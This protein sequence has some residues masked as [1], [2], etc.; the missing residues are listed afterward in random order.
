M[1]I[2]VFFVK[3]T[4]SP[5]RLMN[6]N[7]LKLSQHNSKLLFSLFFLSFFQHSLHVPLRAEGFASVLGRA[8]AGLP[9]ALHGRA[10][11]L[12]RHWDVHH[13]GRWGRQYGLGPIPRS[14]NGPTG[15][16]PAHRTEQ[17]DRGNSAPCSPCIT[18]RTVKRFQQERCLWRFIGHW[19]MYENK[20]RTR[21]YY[22]FKDVSAFIQGSLSAQ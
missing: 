18:R 12:Q 8:S 6:L 2:L 21:L 13:L 1:F 7:C 9:D 3:G 4:L 19:I 14:E 20:S 16:H 22:D 15:P 10:G 17:R 5:T 11:L